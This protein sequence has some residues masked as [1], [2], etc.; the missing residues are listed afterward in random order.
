M[1]YFLF[2]QIHVEVSD[3]GI[4]RRTDLTL[5][6]V[7]MTRNLFSPEFRPAMYSSVLEETHAV[8]SPFTAVFATDSDASVSL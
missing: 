1:L 2:L 7:N 3:N 8:G 5:V 6:Y 4:P